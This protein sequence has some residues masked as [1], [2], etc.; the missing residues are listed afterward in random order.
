MAHALETVSIGEV[1]LQVSTSKSGS[2]ANP[3]ILPWSMRGL[4]DEEYVKTELDG[5]TQELL[6][7][8]DAWKPS[9]KVLRDVKFRL[10]AV[11]SRL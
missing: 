9:S 8:F 2:T 5:E 3:Y 6:G 10:E 1:P 7:Q 11:K 4:L